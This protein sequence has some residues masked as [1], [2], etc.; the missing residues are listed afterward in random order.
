MEQGMTNRFDEY[1]HYGENNPP[2]P[3]RQITV[4]R[5]DWERAL[6]LLDGEERDFVTEMVAKYDVSPW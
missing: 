2:L 1:D 6:V 4:N 3:E 5:Q